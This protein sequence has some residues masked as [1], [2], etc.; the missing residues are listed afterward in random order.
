MNWQE[1]GALAIVACTAVLMTW[2]FFTRKKRANDPCDACRAGS[3][4]Q[5]S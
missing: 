5:G 4:N 2:S 1:F 3:H